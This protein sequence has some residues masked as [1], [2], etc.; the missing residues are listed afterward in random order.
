MPDGKV[1]ISSYHPSP[2]NVNTKRLTENIMITLLKE[3]FNEE[4][5]IDFVDHIYDFNYL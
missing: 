5:A 4:M 1:L 3:N 2:R